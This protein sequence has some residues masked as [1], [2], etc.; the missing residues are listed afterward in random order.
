[1]GEIALPVA[2]PAVLALV[3]LDPRVHHHVQLQPMGRG[4]HLHKTH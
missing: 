1:M 2:S 4:E 3:R